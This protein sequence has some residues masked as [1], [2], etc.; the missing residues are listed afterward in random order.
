MFFQVLHIT[1]TFFDL[2]SASNCPR[3][4]L[5][6]HDG[7]SSADFPLGRYCGST[8]PQGVHSSANSLYFH[9]YSEYIKRGRGFTARWEAKLPGK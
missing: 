8:P 5:Q 7:D 9:L 3:E 1:F 4:Y 6:I 2:E